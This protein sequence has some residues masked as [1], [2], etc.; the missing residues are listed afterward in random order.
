MLKFP[1]FRIAT[2]LLFTTGVCVI[3]ALVAKEY[4]KPIVEDVGYQV[5]LELIDAPANCALSYVLVAE[6]DLDRISEALESANNFEIGHTSSLE[7][8][9]ADLGLVTSRTFVEGRFA[10]ID[11]PAT[12]STT[13]LLK[14]QVQYE[15][16]FDCLIIEVYSAGRCQGICFRRRHDWERNQNQ[17][18]LD[19]GKFLKRSQA[20]D[21]KFAEHLESLKPSEDETDDLER[22]LTFLPLQNTREM[23]PTGTSLQRFARQLFQ[24]DE[25]AYSRPKTADT[26]P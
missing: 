21:R 11:V 25:T 9:E 23:V 2:L 24:V 26:N 17:L 7:M 22:N 18:C 5:T 10:K 8:S 4:G 3:T 6:T 16:P 14:K 19:I 12:R 13:P 15:I 20:M 1:K